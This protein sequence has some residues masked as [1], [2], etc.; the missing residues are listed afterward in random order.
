MWFAVYA[1][2]L[3]AVAQFLGGFMAL[4]Q[5]GYYTAR[6]PAAFIRDN[7]TAWGWI[8]L[9]LGVLT[10]IVIAGLSLALPWA[11]VGAVLIALLS[12]IAQFG[13]VSANPW[14]ATFTIAVDIL[15][16]YAVIVHGGEPEAEPAY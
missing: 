12:A 6:H 9:G 3:V 13:F 4:L 7:Y 1:L 14:W 8:H 11:R 2:T 10:V 16:I 5:P 15:V